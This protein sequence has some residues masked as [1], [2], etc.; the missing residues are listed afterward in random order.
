M[1]ILQVK[2][3]SK[4]LNIDSN[5]TPCKGFPI[6]AHVRKDFP[7]SADIEMFLF[8]IQYPIETLEPL[9]GNGHSFSIISNLN[10]STTI[11]TP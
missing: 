1:R 8:P 6:A 5:A 3:K 11:S 4:I 10:L 2:I 7:P 9:S